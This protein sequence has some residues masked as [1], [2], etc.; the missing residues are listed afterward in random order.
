MTW[1][2]VLKVISLL[3]GNQLRDKLPNFQTAQEKGY[4]SILA[5]SCLILH[6]WSL[7]NSILLVMDILLLNLEVVILGGI[8]FLLGILCW[9]NRR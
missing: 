1:F 2:D 3:E 6:L 9:I 4:P 7:I 5:K 8:L